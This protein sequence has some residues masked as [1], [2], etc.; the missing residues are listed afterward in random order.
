[1][2]GAVKLLQYL[3]QRQ[4]DVELLVSTDLPIDHAS[5]AHHHTY[6]HHH[7]HNTHDAHSHPDP[8]NDSNTQS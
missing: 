8:N 6:R 1:M 3:N 2:I 7:R 5:D 4:A